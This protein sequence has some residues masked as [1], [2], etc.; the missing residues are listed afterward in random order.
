MKKGPAVGFEPTTFRLQV[1]CTTTVLCWQKFT[2]TKHHSNF[3]AYHKP[4]S[5]TSSRGKQYK[6]LKIFKFNCEILDFLPK[7]LFFYLESD[8]AIAKSMMRLSIICDFYH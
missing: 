4:A 7:N 1:G 3:I 2:A 6:Y 5:H 8:F